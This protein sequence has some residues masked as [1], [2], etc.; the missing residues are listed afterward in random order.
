[1]RITYN[2]CCFD[3]VQ[4]LEIGRHFLKNSHAPRAVHFT[5]VWRNNDPVIPTKRDGPF[6]VPADGQHGLLQ[7][8]RQV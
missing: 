1:M 7:F 8:P 3:A 5:D 6:H 2:S 4:L